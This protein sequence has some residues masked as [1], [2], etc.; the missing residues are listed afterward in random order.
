MRAGHQ[1]PMECEVTSRDCSNYKEASR[2]VTILQMG[3]TT[4]SAEYLCCGSLMEPLM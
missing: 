3:A 2:S 4:W 1:V